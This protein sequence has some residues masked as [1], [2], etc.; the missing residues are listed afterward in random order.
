MLDVRCSTFPKEIP[1]LTEFD[2]SNVVCVVLAGGRGKRMGSETCHKVCFPV[3]GRPAIVRAIDTYKEAGITRFVVVV[4]QM[5]DQVLETV[6]AAHPE[7]M[8]VRQPDPR[9]TGHAAMVA[10][11]ALAAQRHEGSVLI[12]M[13]D[14]VTNADT[15]RHL[16]QTY[17]SHEPDVLMSVLPK[18]QETT[19]GRVLEDD[20]GKVL[21]I[22][23]CADIRRAREQGAT[24]TVG[25]HAFT[26]DEVEQ[27]GLT[28][29]ASMYMF[30]MAPLHRALRLLSPANAQG[31]LYLTDT[32]ES[33]SQNGR[34]ERL[35]IP[36][37]NDLM[38]FN[39]P[40]ELLA[41]EKV[42]RDREGR[43]LSTFQPDDELPSSI[44][45]PAKQWLAQ[46]HAFTPATRKTLAQMYGGDETVV[47]GRRQAMIQAVQAFMG[48]FGPDRK[49]VLC[50][51]PGRINL[52]GRHVDHRGGNVN[53]MAINRETL[54]AASPREDDVVRLRDIRVNHFPNREFRIY[55]LLGEESW[56]NWMD[57]LESSTVT[58]VLEAAPGDW[59]H[60]V[61]APLLRL[62]YANR[63]RRLKGMDCMLAGNIPMAAG[64]SSSSAL[65][66]AFAEAAVAL[67]GLDFELSDFIDLC[68]EGEWFVGSRGGAADHAAIRTGRL[69]HVTRIGFFPFEVGESTPMPADLRLMIANSGDRAVKSANARDVFNQRVAC[70]EFALMLLKRHWPAAAGAEHLRDLVPEALGVDARDF[71]RALR[72]LPENPSREELEPLLKQEDQAKVKRFLGTHVDVG[73][74]NLRGVALFGVAECRRSRQFG[75]LLQAGDLAGIGELM[76]ASHDG[77]RCY[78]PG[79]EGT[80]A[81]VVP[82]DDAALAA[83]AE[84]N[85]PL[86]LQ[87][88]AYACSTANI[89]RLVDIA[90]SVDGVIGAQLAGAG[91]G[92]CMMSLVRADAVEALEQRFR[93]EY[94]ERIGREPDMHVCLPVAGAGLIS[95]PE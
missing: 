84:A 11:D 59:S 41:I 53:V 23:E 82:T 75:T 6:S 93:S 74:Y 5:A 64:L 3:G 52:M 16:L 30:R 86:A 89:D 63:D 85:A 94:Y 18:V 15:V 70:Y 62:Q 44:Y 12:V 61:R 69:G 58:Q 4:G 57:F 65:V 17:R 49:M 24:L 56:S 19:A 1:P 45:K 25:G 81:F 90:N 78:V 20:D 55:D 68:G 26:A 91:L 42:I 33:I 71:Y 87:P 10:V 79:S 48:Q 77:D 9:G 54:L 37:P 72:L 34:V 36:D 73:P 95:L 43:P 50:R 39:T 7:V 38:A 76:Q 88:G 83:L 46:L 47:A 2:V 28:V 8:F 66:V 51:A 35:L 80:E 31:E 29:N 92:G 32:V 21:G 27:K 13:G 60:Y 67:N 14:K 22:V 40:A